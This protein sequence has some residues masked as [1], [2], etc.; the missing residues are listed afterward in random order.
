MITTTPAPPWLRRSDQAVT[1]ARTML[2]PGRA[3]VIDCETTDLPGALI[4]VAVLDTTGR[5]LLNTLVNPGSP[6]SA[7]AS[8]VHHITDQMVAGASGFAEVLDEILRVTTGR[9]VLAYNAPFDYECLQSDAH[10]HDRS[11]E[12]LDDPDTWGASCERDRPGLVARTT[13][14]RWEPH[15]VQS[16]MRWPRS[17]SCGR[18]PM[19]L[20]SVNGLRPSNSTR[21][22]GRTVRDRARIPFL[23]RRPS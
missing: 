3:V 11:C 14:T 13:T 16:G 22:S 15:I 6:I 17:P 10:R 12:H 23:D 2:S 21:Y 20:G 19:I 7:G 5:I 4:E 8:R 9:R 1:W 18:S